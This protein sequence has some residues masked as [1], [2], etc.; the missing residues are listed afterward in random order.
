MGWDVD[1][2]GLHNWSLMDNFEWERGYDQRFG[3]VYVDFTT[4]ERIPKDSFGWYREVISQNA[5]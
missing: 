5:N 1:P 3:L 2:E 4:Q